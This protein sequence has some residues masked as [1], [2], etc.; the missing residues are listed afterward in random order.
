MEIKILGPGCPRCE[1][2]ERMVR[3]AAAELG[4]EPTFIKVKEINEIRA[5]PISVTPGLV[6]NEEL[7][8][9]GRFPRKKE[10]FDWLN[11]AA[12]SETETEIEAEAEAD[13]V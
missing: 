1:R 11:E 6:I 7:K 12:Q 13:D 9:H 4:I 10:L 5:Y 2:L 8:V 3:D